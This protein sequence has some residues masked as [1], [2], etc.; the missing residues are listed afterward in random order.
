MARPRI[1][2][3]TLPWELEVPTLSLAS[4]AAVTP[5]QFDVAIVDLLRQRLHLDEPTDLVGITAS[6]PR[7]KAAYALADL[8][9]ARGVKV[10]L[11]GHHASAMPDEALQ[12]A[13]A[14]VVGEGETAWRRLCEDFLVSPSRVSGIHRDPAPDL[15]TLPQPRVDLMHLERYGAWY[16]PLIASRGCPEACSFCFAKRMTLG[17]RTYPI[18]HVL[19]QVRRRPAWVKGCYFV[20]DNLTAD[21]DYARELFRALS[22]FGVVFGMQSRHEFSRE[23]KDLALARRAGC[24][25]I[26]SGYESINQASL[27]GT[28]KRSM[29][30]MHRETAAAQF[31]EGIIPSGNWMFGFDWDE[32]DTFQR[33]LD[34]LDST[35]LL[36]CS[37]TTEIPFPGTQA[38]K[39]YR[40]EGRLLTEDYDE[41]VGK[42]HVVVRP[43]RMTPEELRDGVRWLATHYY[44]A[45]RCARRAVKAAKNPHLAPLGH[46]TR[47][48]ALLGLQAFQLWQWHYRMV[49]SLQWLYRRIL[50]VNKHRYFGDLL[51]RT[52]FWASEHRPAGGP[53]DVELSLSGP[54]IATQGH[55]PSP[56]RKLAPSHAQPRNPARA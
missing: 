14:V 27:D 30:D 34:F 55:K 32:P 22:R 10:V 29:A 53:A 38:W 45:G 9:R 31:R 3:I 8:Y 23:G 24:I 46:F 56:R 39:A 28:G 4:L 21:P 16:Y 20:D 37:F 51:R 52:D 42:D 2:L 36:H 17:Y 48:P 35:D 13:D 19:E 47:L 50:S 7:I 26:S 54:F 49:P 5:S 40:L 1:K 44:S 18:A 43:A 12:H 6:T 41:F 25:L 33:T 11:G 15:S